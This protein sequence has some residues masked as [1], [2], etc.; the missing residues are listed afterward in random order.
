VR[1]SSASH[2]LTATGQFSVESD[3]E[4]WIQLLEVRN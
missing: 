3:K 4:E 2:E 1:N